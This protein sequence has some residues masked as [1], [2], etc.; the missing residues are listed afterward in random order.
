MTSDTKSNASDIIFSTNLSFIPVDL[1]YGPK[2][3]YALRLVQPVKGHAQY[4][5]RDER[6]TANRE[7]FGGFSPKEPSPFRHPRSAVPA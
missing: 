7:E 2:G 3:V 4:S 1:R 5:L 6:E